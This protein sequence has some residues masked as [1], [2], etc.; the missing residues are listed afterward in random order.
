MYW[1]NFSRKKH[2]IHHGLKKTVLYNEGV[3]RY[4]LQIIQL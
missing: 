1:G 4:E 2:R 3:R